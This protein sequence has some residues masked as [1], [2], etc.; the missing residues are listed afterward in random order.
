MYGKTREEKEEKILE[1]LKILINNGTNINAFDSQNNTPLAI[2]VKENLPLVISWLVKN[3]AD[4]NTRNKSGDTPLKLSLLKG[5][6][7]IAELLRQHG[8]KE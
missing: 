1:M 7:E 6:K 5:Q 4:V 3:G 8:A 2:A